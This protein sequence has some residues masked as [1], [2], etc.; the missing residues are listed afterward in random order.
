M[1]KNCKLFGKIMAFL[2]LCLWLGLAVTVS[3]DGDTWLAGQNVVIN[4]IRGS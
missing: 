2:S 3:A 4:D 1:K